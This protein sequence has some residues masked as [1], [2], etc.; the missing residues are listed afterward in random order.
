MPG[1]VTHVYT[2]T[3]KSPDKKIS[4]ITAISNMIIVLIGCGNSSI[5]KNKYTA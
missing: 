1:I 4:A 5:F 3:P 2:L